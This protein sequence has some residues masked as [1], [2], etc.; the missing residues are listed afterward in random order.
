MACKVYMKSS[1]DTLTEA[2]RSERMSRVRCRDTQPEMV[3]RRLVHAMGYRY[4]LHDHQLPG[5]PDLVFTSRRKVIFVHGCFWHRHPG[6]KHS[7]FP[8]S[9]ER[10][11]F[12]RAKFE[13]NVRRDQRVQEDLKRTG[14][15]VLVIWEC[16]T[17]DKAG[18]TQ[19]LTRFLDQ[20][21]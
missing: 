19:Q 3:V 5:K 6:C 20:D 1:R 11:E 14:W 8:K 18:L 12:W 10:A 21:S 7:R 15:E 2:D 9:P 13:G 16:V 4:R 17:R